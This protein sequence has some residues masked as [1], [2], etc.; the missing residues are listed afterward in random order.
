[1]HG[2]LFRLGFLDGFAGLCIAGISAWGVF[3]KFA[4]L[5]TRTEHAKA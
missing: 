4:K 1:M 3:L 2:Y 5:K